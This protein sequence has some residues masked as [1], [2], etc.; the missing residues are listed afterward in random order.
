MIWRSSDFPLNTIVDP[1]AMQNTIFLNTLDAQ[2]ITR[3]SF[4]TSTLTVTTSWALLP[5]LPE[6]PTDDL[7]P[8]SVEGDELDLLEHR[9][10]GVAR[11]VHLNG[12]GAPPEHHQ[13]DVLC[14]GPLELLD[15]AQ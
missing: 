15:D 2:L 4:L 11:V 6:P 1:E 9:G 14:H 3:Y 5:A 7:I 8:A 12:Q 10:H 13:G